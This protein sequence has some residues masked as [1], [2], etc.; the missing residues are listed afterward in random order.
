MQENSET[1]TCSEGAEG[2]AVIP[3]WSYLKSAT[4]A[5]YSVQIHVVS[6]QVVFAPSQVQYLF[7]RLT[8]K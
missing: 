8:P 1:V 4:D 6:V 2:E 3:R 7:R 5:T